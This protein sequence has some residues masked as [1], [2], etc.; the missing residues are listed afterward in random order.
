MKVQLQADSLRVRVDEAELTALLAGKVLRLRTQA[1]A[2]TLFALRVE[3]A[4]AS[5][6]VPGEQW[7]LALPLETVRAYAG[8]LPRRDALALAFAGLRVDF[9]V[10][11][12]DSRKVRG[13]R[14]RDVLEAG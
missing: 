10:D 14:S 3:L 6:L 12:R 13:P 5:V 9:E 8:T 1:G 7:R 2:A 4:P 11:A